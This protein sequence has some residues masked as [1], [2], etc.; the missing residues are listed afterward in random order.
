MSELPILKIS[1][2]NPFIRKI[3]LLY[4]R[5]NNTHTG[6]KY[7]YLCLSQDWLKGEPD[8]EP[9]PRIPRLHS[10]PS[11]KEQSLSKTLCEYL[12]VEGRVPFN[13]FSTRL[14]RKPEELHVS[15]VE[16]VH[17][18]MFCHEQ[19]SFQLGKG[20]QRR[21]SSPGALLTHGPLSCGLDTRA[22]HR[23]AGAPSQDWVEEA[24]GWL[25]SEPRPQA[26]VLWWIRGLREAVRVGKWVLKQL[27]ASEVHPQ[28][29]P[30]GHWEEDSKSH[31]RLGAGDAGRPEPDLRQLTV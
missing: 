12:L 20:P 15:R 13:R 25:G 27:P 23:P 28:S 31:C 29:H 18:D 26:T 24:G 9:R 10:Q 3:N 21:K 16:D 17:W 5:E 4:K 14:L 11:N 22:L 2:I 1:L 7:I 19:S 6:N 8:L 30:A